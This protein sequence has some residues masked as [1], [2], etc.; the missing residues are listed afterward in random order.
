VSRDKP[1][2][3]LRSIIW[4]WIQRHGF[5]VS[6][7]AAVPSN[8]IALYDD[9]YA[10]GAAAQEARVAELEAALENMVN[11]P[12]LVCSYVRLNAARAALARAAPT[13][14]EGKP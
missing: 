13:R 6:V 8:L 2:P 7:D 10:A 12:A 14:W 11:D 9:A 4:P 3:R 5:V 1:D